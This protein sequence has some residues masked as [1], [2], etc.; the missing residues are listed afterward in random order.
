MP[1]LASLDPPSGGANELVTPEE[2][3]DGKDVF[4]PACGDRMRPRGGGSSKK[5]RHF[6]HVESVGGRN[7]ENGCSGLGRSFGESKQHRVMKSLAASGLRTR[8]L[9]TEEIE[10]CGTEVAVDVSGS[11]SENSKRRA[12][13][14]IQFSEE[15]RFFGEG[16]AVEVQHSNETKNIP[17]VTSDYLEVGFSV[18]W[19]SVEDFTDDR[20]L[21]DRFEEAFST[22]NGRAFAPYFADRDHIWSE[23]DVEEWFTLSEGWQLDDPNSDC[24]HEFERE[25][26]SARCVKCGTRYQRHSESGVPIYSAHE[27]PRQWLSGP[28][29]VNGSDNARE[30]DG[31]P[32]VHVWSSKG[33]SE[34]TSRFECSR[35]R[36]KKVDTGGEIVIDYNSFSAESVETR[37]MKNCHHEWRRTGSGEECWKC[38][39]PKSVDEYERW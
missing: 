29:V 9:T 6:F 14:L 3:P 16:V 18:F 28:V 5:A 22:R 11:A 25:K 1:F 31:H 21:L 4:C 38:G 34:Y 19:A 2:V 33:S 15:N 20:F 24:S 13:A 7:A 8:F 17:L 36:A 10:L 37:R 12:D 35:C 23:Y 32:H 27:G 30:P 39:K 26:G